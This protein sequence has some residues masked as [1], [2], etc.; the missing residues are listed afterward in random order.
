MSE[1]GMILRRWATIVALALAAPSLAWADDDL[2]IPVYP[3]PRA[4]RAPVIDAR[5]DDA[6]WSAAPVASGFTYFE[7]DKLAPVQTSFRIAYDDAALYFAITCDEPTPQKVSRVK[8]ARDD[9]AIFGHEAVEIFI[10]PG[11]THSAY[12]QLGIDAAGSLYDVGSEQGT[13]WNGHI[14]VATAIGNDSWRAEV[15]V[16]WQDLGVQPKPGQVHGFNVCR[17]RY[18]GPDRQWSNWARVMVTFHDPIRFAH[19]VLSPTPDVLAGLAAELRKGGRAG[20]IRIFTSEGVAGR[21]YGAMLKE[22]LDKM[23]VRIAEL[24]GIAENDRDPAVRREMNARLKPLEAEV[25]EARKATSSQGL[26]AATFTRSEVR[27][28]GVLKELNDLVWQARLS[29]LLEEL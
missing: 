4:E 16:P 9:L 14:A 27:L 24:R 26:D 23:N 2:P 5:F 1:A 22:T 13:V 10:D 21:V 20:P 11:H 25:D 3:C 6:C 8:G 18:I 7:K 29:A 15:A 12:Y 19:L 28:N 17:D